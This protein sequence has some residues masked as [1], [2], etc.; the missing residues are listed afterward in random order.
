[1]LLL[2]GG[3]RIFDWRNVV[4]SA[5]ASAWMRPHSANWGGSKLPELRYLG[6]TASYRGEAATGDA[7]VRCLSS[8]PTTRG[9]SYNTKKV[10]NTKRRSFFFPNYSLKYKIQVQLK[11]QI[12]VTSH[13]FLFKRNILLLAGSLSGLVIYLFFYYYLEKK[14]QYRLLIHPSQFPV[15]KHFTTLPSNYLHLFQWVFFFKCTDCYFSSVLCT[16]EGQC[17]NK[18]SPRCVDVRAECIQTHRTACFTPTHP[19]CARAGVARETS[20]EVGSQHVQYKYY[21]KKQ[22]KT[23]RNT[24]RDIKKG[25][26][27]E[28]RGRS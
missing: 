28:A 26:L 21:K 24:K 20:C 23:T 15:E 22:N 9:A 17:K 3:C 2:S 11:F 16:H 19:S 10:T 8:P 12:L 7:V 4:S 27:E 1:M 5:E 13:T 6:A 18:S 25:T 14:S